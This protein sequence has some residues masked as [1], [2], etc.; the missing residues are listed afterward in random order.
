MSYHINI[1]SG[2][3]LDENAIFIV[4]A[5]NTKLILGSGVSMCFKRHCGKELQDEMDKVLAS[6]D[7]D[8]E[9]GDV[10]ATSSANA[11]NFSY[12]LHVATINYNKHQ[13]KNPTLTIIETALK[14]IENYLIWY[15]NHKS[16]NITLAIPLLG[17][18]A[19]G[20]DKTEVLELYKKFF[21]NE[22]DINC[23]IHIYI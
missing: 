17:C 19:G 6:I 1:K 15:K 7:G 16:D 8:I 11:K 5:S 9:H 13:Q 23:T 18:G 22:I 3:L 14:N 4:N 20:L 12:A 21:A 2:N 10:V